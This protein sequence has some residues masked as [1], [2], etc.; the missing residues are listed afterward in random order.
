MYL[1]SDL[2]PKL[3]LRGLAV[4]CCNPQYIISVYSSILPV[5]PVCAPSAGELP[6]YSHSKCDRSTPQGEEDTHEGIVQFTGCVV[7][8][9]YSIA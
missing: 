4:A 7:Q 6:V 9:L 8:H 2:K 5:P 1:V 3:I